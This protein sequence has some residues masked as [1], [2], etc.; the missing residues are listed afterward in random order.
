MLPLHFYP[1]GPGWL[2]GTKTCGTWYVVW[3]WYVVYYTWVRGTI[4]IYLQILANRGRMEDICKSL[5]RYVAICGEMHKKVRIYPK[6]VY[7]SFVGLMFFL[8]LLRISTKTILQCKR[9]WCSA[10]YFTF[11]SIYKRKRSRNKKHISI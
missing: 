10:H 3:L 4:I 11:A 6:I 2:A 7:C 8:C 9:S 1:D 5:F